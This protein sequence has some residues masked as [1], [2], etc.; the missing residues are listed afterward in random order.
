MY[1]APIRKAMWILSLASIVLSACV[2]G[3]NPNNSQNQAATLA[4]QT[5]TAAQKAKAATATAFM[6]STATPTPKATATPTSTPTPV[7]QA[8]GPTNFPANYDPLTGLPVSDP[9]ILNRR[10]VMIKVANFPA[11]GRPH[12]GLSFADIVFEYFIG[13]GTNRFLAL[14]YG[15][16]A[17]QVG[18][19]RSGRLIDAQLVPMYQGILGYESAYVTVLNAIVKAL[20]KR[21]IIGGPATCPGI[22][23]NGQHTV[24]SVFSD[25]A[26][27]SEYA[28]KIGVDNSKP[29]L[30]GMSFDPVPPA[31]GQPATDITVV[32]NIQDI[33]EWRYDAASHTYLRWIESV[34]TKGNVTMVPLTDRLTNKQ[35]SFNNVVVLFAF[36]NEL[37]P[38]LHEV[39]MAGNTTGQRAI[40]FRDGQAYDGTWK[41][42]GPDKPI[43]FFT[44]DGKDLAFKPGNSWIN[45]EGINTSVQTPSTGTWNFHF[46]LP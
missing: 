16:N 41:S 10:P 15:Q 44:K 30:D 8:S 34:D 24:I 37:A 29:N 21:A 20:G 27:L 23:D 22:C 4:A 26:A 2:F 18:P 11:T 33:G 43:Q 17:T 38:T 9:T 7:V 32:Y 40:L 1:R 31:G 5:A 3:S 46:Y 28:T 39:T 6:P 45:I 13:E 25:T 36:Y 14:Y 19:I 35:L 12:A 42:A